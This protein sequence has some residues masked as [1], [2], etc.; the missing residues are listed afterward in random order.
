[1][2]EMTCEEFYLK[3]IAPVE[4]SPSDYREFFD[5]LWRVH[6][7]RI[8]KYAHSWLGNVE[9]ARDVCQDA[10]LRAMRYI[11]KHPGRIPLKVN[12]GA[13]LTVITRHLVFDRFRDPLVRSGRVSRGTVEVVAAEQSPEER[14]ITKELLAI[15][16]KCIAALTE[17]A[18]TILTLRDLRGISEKEVAAKLKSK[19]NA[20]SVALHRARKALRECVTMAISAGEG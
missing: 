11:Q 5:L 16:R 15:L 8:F 13:W 12:F 6:S 3:K 1:M 10:F 14:A 7:E 20:I 2:P 19:P 9:D 17:R 4:A 18:R